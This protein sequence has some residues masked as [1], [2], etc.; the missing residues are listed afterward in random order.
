GIECVADGPGPLLD[1]FAVP[2]GA[3]GADVRDGHRPGLDPPSDDLVAGASGHAGD[4]LAATPHP[5]A[6]GGQGRPAVQLI[7]QTPPQAR[8]CCGGIAHAVRVLE[9]VGPDGVE[10]RDAAWTAGDLRLQQQQR[11]EVVPA[12]A[13]IGDRGTALGTNTSHRWPP[14]SHGPR[15]AERPGSPAGAAPGEVWSRG[16]EACGPGQVRPPGSVACVWIPRSF[17]GLRAWVSRTRS[18]S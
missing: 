12:R 17:D 10:V 5:T 15:A 14:Q 13:A 18:P 9:G 8:E 16:G 1:T 4:P 11:V 2:L 6:E 7:R 3:P